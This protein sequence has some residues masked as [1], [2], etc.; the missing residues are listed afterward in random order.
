MTIKWNSPFC[1]ST[2]AS[3]ANMRLY[4]RMIITAEKAILAITITMYACIL[5]F[6]HGQTAQ[7]MEI[8]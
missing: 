6:Q 3:E 4:T 2:G 5:V 7:F 1:N 8:L